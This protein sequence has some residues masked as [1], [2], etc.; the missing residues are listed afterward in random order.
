MSFDCDVVMNK[1]VYRSM[2]YR[3]FSK[4]YFVVILDVLCDVSLDSV[5]NVK[6]LRD[7]RPRQGTGADGFWAT[8]WLAL[9][10]SR[11]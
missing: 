1:P 9:S 8:K 5:P 3:A 10:R 2:R 4:R 7:T 11:T 6:K